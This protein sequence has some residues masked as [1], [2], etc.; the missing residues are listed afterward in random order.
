LNARTTAF[1]TL[2]ASAA[3]ASPAAG[4]ELSYTFLDIGAATVETSL[5][6]VRMPAPGQTVSVETG[7]GDGLTVG[8]SLAIGQRFYIAAANETAVIGVDAFVASPLATAFLGGNV[9]RVASRAAVG[10]VQPIGADFD[11]I[12]EV[13]HDT[14]EYDFGSF[15]GESFDIDEGGTGFGV[16]F[17]WNPTSAFELFAL[18]HGSEVGEIDLTSGTFESGTRAVA[19]LRWYFFEDLGLGFDFRSG[20]ADSINV[21]LRFGFGDLRAG[22]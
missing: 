10:Y 15:A 1:S 4:S 14:V 3:C 22:Y 11:F 8:G 6:G 20:D 13:A 2:I 5:D 19:G 9:D 18:A 17:R 12:F 21:S 16:G 7:A